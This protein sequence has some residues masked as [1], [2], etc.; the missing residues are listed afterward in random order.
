MKKRTIASL[1]ALIISTALLPS[2]GKASDKIQISIGMWPQSQLISDV[3][4]YKEWKKRFETDYLQ[5][6]IVGDNYEY[7][8]ATVQAKAQAHKLPTI[9]QTWFTEPNMLVSKGYVKDITSQLTELGW[10]DKMDTSM[11]EALTFDGKTYGVPRDGYGLGL[12]LNTKALGEAGLLP[13]NDGDG[14]YEIYNKDGTPAYPTTF[15]KIIEVS[16]KKLVRNI[17]KISIFS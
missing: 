14:T 7:S 16:T 15:E 3:N 11:K 1:G 6:E 9:F 5:Y 12:L 10:L 2:C 4:M 17:D 8:V 13:D